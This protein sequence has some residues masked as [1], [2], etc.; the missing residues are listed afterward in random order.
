MTDTLSRLKVALADRYT[1]ERELGRGGMATVYL[2]G[3]LKHHRKVAIK[4]LRPELAASIGADRFLREIEI[5]ANLNHPH[6]LPL[7]DSGE[8]D[9]LL[10]Y[11]MPFVQGESLRDKLNRERQLSIDD[12]LKITSEVADALGFAHSHGIVHRDIKPENILLESDHAVVTD[13]GIA[14]AVA[15]AGGER[16]TETG[17]AVGTP[18]YMS[19]EQATGEKDLDGRSDQ[20]S[21]ACVLYEML[22]GDPPFTGVTPQAIIS[23]KLSEPTPRISV[24]RELIPAAMEAALVRGLAKTPADRYPSVRDMVEGLT[25]EART[26]RETAGRKARAGPRLRRFATIVAAAVILIGASVAGWITVRHKDGSS[27]ALENIVV[28]APFENRT[29]DESQD[30]IGAIAADQVAGALTDL[31]GVRVIPP[32]EVPLIRSS[33][34]GSRGEAGNGA[35]LRELGEAAGA[36]LVI[37][38]SYYVRGVDLEFQSQVVDVPA[39][40]TIIFSSEPFRGPMDDPLEAL[41]ELSGDLAGSVASHLNVV[42]TWGGE[43]FVEQRR[44][45]NIQALRA[46]AEG[47]TAGARGDWEESAR[48]LYRAIDLDSTF[49]AAY[50]T[51]VGGALLNLHRWEEMD[52]VYRRASRA[53]EDLTELERIMLSFMRATVNGDLLGILASQQAKLAVAPDPTTAFQ[54]VYQSVLVNH[55][56]IGVETFER[57]PDLGYWEPHWYFETTARHM[58]G[59]HRRELEEARRG[60]E[61]FP[62]SVFLMFMEARALAALGETQQLESLLDEMVGLGAGPNVLVRI[63]EDLD[64]HGFADAS[65]HL[66]QRVQD[67]YELHLEEALQTVGG[68][69][70]RATTLVRFGRLEEARRI[71]EQQ[72]AENPNSIGFRGY[73]GVVAARMGDRETADAVDRQLAALDEP[74]L[75]GNQFAWRARIAAVLGER[76]LAVGLLTTAFAGG[77][78]H[79]PSDWKQGGGANFGTW[80]AAWLHAE[81]EFESLRDYPPFQELMRPKG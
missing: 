19:P 35:S 64:V 39:G 63:A 12:A 4:V 67:W 62:N 47:R 46:Y 70:W 56:R 81:P 66:D 24:V 25:A 72:L 69:A 74:Y 76:E 16:L 60:R 7:H 53:V 34:E 17:M 23:K 33:V 51:L 37:T 3:D 59:E 40:G 13:F 77:L 71:I 1:I 6:I 44:P 57:S 18:A 30:V 11:I 21:L 45:P 54:I 49:L 27:Q 61:R 22:G 58:L 41:R 65:S 55:P 80:H 9:G 48:L 68:Q 8:A 79:H 78:E 36:V 52:S 31:P 14:K 10:Y 73:L 50:G 75:F 20:Y 29:G 5:A 43:T 28:V 32:N 42:D 38:G 26:V 15:E 2:A